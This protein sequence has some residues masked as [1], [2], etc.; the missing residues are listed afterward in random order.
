MTS[1]SFKAIGLGAQPPQPE[2]GLM[3]SE[4]RDYVLEQWW[5]ATFPG[6]IIFLVVLSFNLVGDGLGDTFDP[7]MKR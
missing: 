4:G 2:L 7:R 1:Q 3:I 5:Y 6:L